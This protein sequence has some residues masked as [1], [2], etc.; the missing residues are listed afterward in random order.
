MTLATGGTITYIWDAGKLWRV[1]T[2]TADG[3]FDVTTGGSDVEY[4]MVAGG[5]SGGR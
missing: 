2:F 1:H 4:F 3:T 5:G